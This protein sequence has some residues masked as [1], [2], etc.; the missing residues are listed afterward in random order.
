[1]SPKTRTP[2]SD[3]HKTA[4]AKGRDQGRAVRR[5]L[6]A[7]EANKPRRGRRRSPESIAKRLDAIETDL[8]TADPLDHPD[9]RP[10]RGAMPAQIAGCRPRSGA[11][12]NPCAAVRCQ[13]AR[14]GLV[15]GGSLVHGRR[16]LLTGGLAVTMGHGE[17]TRG[18][19]RRFPP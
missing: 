7:L 2:L 11:L 13:A 8:P 17:R 10:D 3:E 14:R 15:D 9:V 1:M 19:G 5:Y 4:L 12:I 16:G 6:E 18:P